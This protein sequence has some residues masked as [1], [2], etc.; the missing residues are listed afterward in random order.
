MAPKEPILEQMRRNPQ[1]DWGISD[2]Q[3][4]CDEYGIDLMKPSRGSHY[5]AAS[6]LISAH[7]CIPHNRPIKAIYIKAL[8]AMID[9]H[10]E[11][12]KATKGAE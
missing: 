5:K 3:R 2:V 10:I 7:Q 12:E 9:V 11:F 1:S 4:V 6:P 8:V